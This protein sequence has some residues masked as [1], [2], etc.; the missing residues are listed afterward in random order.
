MLELLEKCE[1]GMRSWMLF[2]RD[3][4]C[5][6]YPDQ[7]AECKYNVKPYVESFREWSMCEIEQNYFSPDKNSRLFLQCN[8]KESHNSTKPSKLKQHTKT[9]HWVYPEKP[10]LLKTKSIPKGVFRKAELARLLLSSISMHDWI[11]LL[12]LLFTLLLQMQIRRTR[13][14]SIIRSLIVFA[15]CVWLHNAALKTPLIHRR[16]Q[17]RQKNKYMTEHDCGTILR[18]WTNQTN[19]WQACHVFLFSFSFSAKHFE[20]H[21]PFA[22]KQAKIIESLIEVTFFVIWLIACCWYG[23]AL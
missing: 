21:W 1:L 19:H 17:V 9:K 22:S 6:A 15:V 16:A 18:L 4:L 7:L 3:S 2:Y 11:L 8:F 12:K 20:W 13:I 5:E 14:Y 10:H 23:I